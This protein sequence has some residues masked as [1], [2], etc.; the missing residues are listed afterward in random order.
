MTNIFRAAMAATV[1]TLALWAAPAAAQQAS[2]SATIRKPLTLTSKQNLN[3]GDI[4]VTGTGTFSANVDVAANGSLVC[5]A[6][7]FTCSG[8]RV[9]A[10]Y[11]VSGN[12]QQQVKLT[13][14]STI[15]LTNTATPPDSLTMTVL[16]P[17]TGDT[18]TLTNSGFPGTDVNL[19]GRLTITDATQDGAYSGSFNVTA[20]YQ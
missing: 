16:L 6:T 20:N 1:A 7:Y 12:K 3:F 18:V 15:T 2:A 8:T 10:I 14:D 5:P 4:L 11:N 19:G 17:S 13:V 9:P